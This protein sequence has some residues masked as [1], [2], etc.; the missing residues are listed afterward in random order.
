MAKDDDCV[1]ERAEKERTVIGVVTRIVNR[2]KYS[3]H[4]LLHHQL[5]RLWDDRN[6]SL[7]VE[8]RLGLLEMVTET[9][10]VVTRIGR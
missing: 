7:W 4:P 2:Q 3:R 8:E 5:F 1:W 9:D 10:G 6:R